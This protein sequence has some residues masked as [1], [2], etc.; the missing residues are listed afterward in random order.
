M[1]RKAPV[2]GKPHIYRV[3]FRGSIGWRWVWTGR[4]SQGGWACVQWTKAHNPP[5]PD[6]FIA[7]VEAKR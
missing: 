4:M 1:K 5:W 2:A 6:A 7:R 3:N